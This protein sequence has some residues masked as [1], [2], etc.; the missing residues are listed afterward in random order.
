MIQ[1]NPLMTIGVAMAHC[2]G[3]WLE[4]GGSR[5]RIL[6]LQATLDHGLPQKI[7]KKFK[8][9]KKYFHD[10]DLLEATQKTFPEILVGESRHAK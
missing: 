9:E 6:N 8:S 10:I 2:H 3:N 4:I 7:Q 1:M 5:V